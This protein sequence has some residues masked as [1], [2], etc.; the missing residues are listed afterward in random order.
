MSKRGPNQQVV[1][2]R[3]RVCI[4]ADVDLHSGEI[5]RVIEDDESV[6]LDDDAVAWRGGSDSERTLYVVEH[7]Y[8]P[9]AKP[10]PVSIT[11]ELAARAIEI[12]DSATWPE[13]ERP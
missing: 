5:I 1:S 2:V 9:D 10:Y 12:A 4:Y 3:Y 8:G 13:W 11:S 7:A 6:R